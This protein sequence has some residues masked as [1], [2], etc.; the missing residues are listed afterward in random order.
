MFSRTLLCIIAVAAV[1][2]LSACNQA[3]NPSTAAA[4][5][6]QPKIGVLLANHGSAQKSWRDKL[7]ELD[8]DVRG[9]I[10]ADPK[11]SDVKTAFM[12][13]TEP[14]IATRMKEFDAEGYDEVIVVPVL[15][16][17][18]G[19][20][21]IDIP[22]L[23]GLSDNPD[24]VERLR[25]RDN[26]EVYRP[27][28]KVILTSLLSSTDFLKKNILRR[29]KALIGDE[30]GKKFGV[31]LAA[32]GDEGYDEQWEAFMNEVGEYLMKETNV[33]MVNYAWSG[34]LVNYSIDPTKD[35]I[36]EVLAKK[37][38]DALI[39]VYVSY[40]HEFQTDII[41]EAAKQSNRP[42][43]VRYHEKEAILPDKNLEDWVVETVEEAAHPNQVVDAST[44]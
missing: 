39:S 19:H 15:V 4:A 30:D 36:N 23:V 12:E 7:T 17:V 18:S 11:I 44:T 28:A 42:E 22:H 10:L 20:S 24:A 43:A 1:S 29:T 16:T 37:E 3:K 34:H 35:A 31:T 26:I 6:H 13:Y 41:G 8:A 25:D 38:E 33:D 5:K 40:D 9:R 14:S 27:H 21:D 2:L 32:Y